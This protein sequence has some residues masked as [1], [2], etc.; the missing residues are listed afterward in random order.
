MHF[1]GLFHDVAPFDVGIACCDVVTVAELMRNNIGKTLGFGLFLRASN[2]DQ[3]QNAPCLE[4]HLGIEQ[5]AYPAGFCGGLVRWQASLLTLFNRLAAALAKGQ[6]HRS[7][8]RGFCFWPSLM[9][10]V[11]GQVSDTPLHEQ[12]KAGAV[13]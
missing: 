11:S 3:R 2:A 10:T 8:L 1:V 6:D 12:A 9:R 5:S 7:I 4:W 13:G